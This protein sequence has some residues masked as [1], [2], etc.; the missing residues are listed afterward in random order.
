MEMSVQEGTFHITGVQ[1]DGIKKLELKKSKDDLIDTC[2]S[3]ISISDKLLE[4]A[5]NNT[6]KNKE[7]KEK[8]FWQGKLEVAEY[9]R[10]FL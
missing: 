5:K 2:K 9:V 10:Y 3:E 1:V 6:D 7:L 8:I 4:N